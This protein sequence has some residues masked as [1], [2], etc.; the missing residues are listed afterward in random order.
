MVAPLTPKVSADVSQTPGILE[1]LVRLMS[2]ESYRGVEKQ[3]HC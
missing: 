2:A 3:D 1:V